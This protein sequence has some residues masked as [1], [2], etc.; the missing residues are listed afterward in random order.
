MET[1]SRCKC[2]AC[3][4]KAINSKKSH[5]AKMKSS[6]LSGRGKKRNMKSVVTLNGNK[7]YKVQ[8]SL[9]C[10]SKMVLDGG[11]KKNL[12]AKRN[13]HP[14]PWSPCHCVSLIY[15]EMLLSFIQ[16]LCCYKPYLNNLR[17]TQT[18][19]ISHSTWRQHPFQAKISV[20][21]LPWAR[22]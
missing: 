18:T 9:Y 3:L 17:C 2:P 4:D 14:H 22:P 1:H 6:H 5:S 13:W 8:K 10:S 21:A 16:F 20:L 12:M 19:S 15:K 11:S 7:V